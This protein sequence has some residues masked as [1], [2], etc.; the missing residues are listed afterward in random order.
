M[1][2]NR[3]APLNRAAASDARGRTVLVT[4]GTSGI[5]R[6]IATGFAASG[7]DVIICARNAGNCARVAEE[8]G[9]AYAGTCTGM[10][11]DLAAPGGIETL[12]EQVTARTD[13]LHVLVHS[14]GKPLI[15]PIDEYPEDGWDQV[16]DLNLRAAFFLVKRFLPLLRAAASED[17][18]ASVINVGSI[19]GHRI[20][21]AE[22]YAY[23]ASKAGLHYLTGSLAKHLG[24]DG[25]T[26][27]AIAPGF[28][29]TEMTEH[30]GDEFTARFKAATPRRR[31][32]M[33]RDIADLACFLASPSA[34]FLTGVTIPLD[35]G[36]AV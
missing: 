20:Q 30:Y 11:A 35:G 27:N 36:V 33:P 1:T 24:P 26:V 13:R 31:L 15:A 16:F 32:G 19:A 29:P 21:Q 25:I 28:F 2:D 14:A 23:A 22:N 17:W 4:G 6:M 3:T 8:I 34:I 18:Q 12:V 5:G 7:A 9:A 10:P